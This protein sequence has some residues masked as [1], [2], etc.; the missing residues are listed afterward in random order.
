MD[1]LHRL[2][3]VLVAMFSGI[4]VHGATIILQPGPDNGK[5]ISLYE[6]TD[7]ELS[8]SKSLYAINTGPPGP[9]LDDFTS[10]IEFDL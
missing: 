4:P 6:R 9:G 7:I 5:D 1:N 10:L 8:S 3:M 2:L